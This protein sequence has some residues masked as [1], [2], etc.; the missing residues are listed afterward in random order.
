[1]NP[2]ALLDP[3]VTAA[4]H[5][6]AALAGLLHALPWGLDVVGALAAVTVG[7]R[8]ALLPL[9]VTARRSVLARAALAPELARLGRRHR[10]DRER[11]AAETLAA[12]RRAGVSPLAGVG[13]M[14][15][16]A[17][18]LATLYRL[19]TL[20]VIAGVPNVVLSAHLFT[21]PLAGHWWAVVAVFGLV[22]PQ[23]AVL[24]MLLLALVLV[25]WASGRSL[26][27]DP[28]S[29]GAARGTGGSV[30]PA[31]RLLRAVPFVTVAFAVVSPVAVGFYLLVSSAWTLA[32]RTALTHLVTL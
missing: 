11:L 2:Y 13:P 6:L 28:A 14:L 26:A 4:H 22:S 16:Q 17:P 25:A 15:A 8:V 31:P 32:E 10:H 30:A 19:V 5:T 24:L 29:A 7:V 12:Y 27:R 3:A 23:A 20:P 18:V 1:V 9:A 21:A